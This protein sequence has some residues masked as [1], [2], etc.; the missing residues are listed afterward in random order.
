[1]VSGSTHGL[2]VGKKHWKFC[3]TI[4]FHLFIKETQ[5]CNELR[6][7]TVPTHINA[8]SSVIKQ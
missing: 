3:T 4:H 6:T 8:G 7:Y 2:R 5:N 1:M